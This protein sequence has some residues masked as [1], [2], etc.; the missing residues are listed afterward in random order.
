MLKHLDR[1]V[2]GYRCARAVR[3]VTLTEVVWA[4][5]VMFPIR[6]ILFG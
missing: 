1:L 4:L 5:D 2:N 3:G 6:Q